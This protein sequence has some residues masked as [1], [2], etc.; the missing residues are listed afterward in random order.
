MPDGRLIFQ[1]D[2]LVGGLCTMDADGSHR[3]Q[4]R[5]TGRVPDV[6][7]AGVVLFHSDAYRIIRREPGG[8][9]LELRDGAFAVWTTDGA[10]V[11]QCQGLGGG[12]CR[13]AADGSALEPLEPAGRVPDA[14]DGGAI[15][16][17]TD[18]YVVSVRTASGVTPLH[19]GANAVWWTRP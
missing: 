16:F 3:E 4:L 1:C 18:A 14:D 9:E 7:A 17:H 8:A 5:S 10:I 11:Y 19:V 13:M 2:G 6:D 15:V 12:L